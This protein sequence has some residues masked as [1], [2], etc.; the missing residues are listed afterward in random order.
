MI[1]HHKSET[2]ISLLSST[3]ATSEKCFVFGVEL[4]M[5]KARQGKAMGYIVCNS[6]GQIM[7]DFPPTHPIFFFDELTSLKK[8]IDGLEFKSF[9]HKLSPF[10]LR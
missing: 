9:M 5:A 1:E 7:T 4:G 2:S 10:V 3:L 8:G 6:L